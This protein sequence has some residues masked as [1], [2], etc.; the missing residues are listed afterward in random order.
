MK[1]IVFIAPYQ[2]ILKSGE[3][4]IK[5]LDFIDKVDCILGDLTRGIAIARQAERNGADVIVTRGGTAELITNA[6]IQV[7]VVEIPITF[8]D[9]AEALL[10]A[11]AITKQEKPKIA[12]M[13]FQNMIRSIEV[14]A[15][16]MDVQ[17]MVYLLRSEEEI[18][19]TVEKA[20]R[21]HPDILIGGMHTTEIAERKGMR[22]I[23]LTSGEESFRTAFLQ[24]EKVSYARRLEKERM[25]KFRVLVDY[26]VQGILSIDGHK[27][28]EIMNT[29]AERLLGRP[30]KQVQGKSLEKLC[31]DLLLDNCLREGQVYRGKLV[32]IQGRK[33]MANVIP[34]DIDGN[35]T[36]AMIT[37]EDVS[38][39]VEMEATI[40]KENYKKGL[41]AQYHLSDII[42][43]SPQ[44][45]SVKQIAEDYAGIDATVLILGASGTGKELFAQGIH[46]ASRR[47]KR[48]F[49]AVNCGAIPSSLLESELFGYVEGA[50]TGANKKGKA[51]FFELAHGGTIFLDEIGEMDKV[52]QMA[53]LRVIQERR[54][55]RLGDD[56]YLP[57]DIRIIA[58]TNKNLSQLVTKGDFREDLY[59]RINVLPIQVPSLKER[60]GDAGILAEHFIGMYNQLFQR[61]VI[62]DKKAKELVNTYEWPGNIRQLRNVMER[63]VIVAKEKVVSSNFLE[64]LFD[65]PA[66]AAL[67]G[68]SL[69][70]AENDCS[71]R[72]KIL[73]VLEE[74]N[75]NQKEASKRLG[76]NRST[77]YRKLKSLGIHLK[78]TC[79]T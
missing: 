30:L 55:M 68:D 38:Q 65:V 66:E 7:P 73:H 41:S 48:P 43:G 23:F 36:G 47:K 35:I 13:A 18:A 33:F 21:D 20:L 45:M 12:V 5:K 62:L 8:Q 44:I 60:R 54:I 19:S 14:F 63:L 10:A 15:K 59:Y 46:N 74:T 49:V 26:S 64:N 72:A 24:A 34:I 56:K 77:L 37:L 4:I 39:I 32:Q 22:T 6:G 70:I 78:R 40:R 25:K 71:E 67:K 53:L 79:T 76:I 69:N 11:K 9:L 42:G 57:V 51:G 58:A 16:V 50:F 2:E 27:R 75:Y 31:P 28:I 1:R 29:A 52:A 17:I 61:E 3:Q